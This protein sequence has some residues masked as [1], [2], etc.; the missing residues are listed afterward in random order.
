MAD[1]EIVIL[2]QEEGDRLALDHGGLMLYGDRER[3]AMQHEFAGQV[4]HRTLPGAPL[5][6]VVG[7]DEENRVQV[8][9]SGTVRLAGDPDAP[10]LQV[11]MMHEFTNVLQQSHEVAIQPMDHTLHVATK[12]HEPIHHALQLRTPVQLRFCNA[13]NVDSDYTVELVIAGMPVVSIRLR[14]RTVVTPQPCG[15]EDCK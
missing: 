15:D 1:E 7:W 9:L 13:W 10:P 2:K 12:L 11:R 5:V 3:P 4:V 14:G 8:E 6:H